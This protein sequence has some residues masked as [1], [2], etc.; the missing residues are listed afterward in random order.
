MSNEISEKDKGLMN[1][2]Q[3][4]M[5]VTNSILTIM[6]GRS[7]SFCNAVIDELKSILRQRCVYQH[8]KEEV[9]FHQSPGI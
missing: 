6:E 8:P 2:P 7:F 3:G 1:E 4:F 9:P 5:Y